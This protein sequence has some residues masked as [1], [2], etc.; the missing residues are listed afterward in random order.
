MN[1][2]KQLF[3]IDP[4]ITF[5]NHGSFGA[6]PKS[7]FEIYQNWQRRLEQQPV[8]FLGRSYHELIHAARKELAIFLG[9]GNNNLVFVPNATYAV[10]Q[11]ARS[12]QLQPGDEVLTGNHE[13][14]A[15]N[16]TWEFICNKAGAVY[17]QQPIPFSATDG[18]I[19]ESF[20]EGV[21]PRTKLIFLSHI[22][23][24]TALRFPVEE[25]CARARRAGIL[26]LIDGA[27]APGQIPLNLDT[28]QADFYTGNCHK[29]M[30]S[31]KG[32]GFLFASP[33]TQH[34]VEPLVVS[35]GFQDPPEFTSGSQ[36]VDMLTWSG[37][38]DPAA[39][40]SVPAAIQFLSDHNWEDV[41]ATC[42]QKLQKFLP[43]FSE[44][45]GKDVLYRQDHQFIQMAVIELPMLKDITSLKTT[46]YEN[47]Q[48]EVPLIDWN[49][50]HFARIS[51]Q[52]YNSEEDLI[53]LLN[54]LGTLLP[55]HRLK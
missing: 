12:L 47:Y 15:C 55:T 37:T 28:L 29:W 53:H 35:W 13:Y 14:G 24:P 2:I 22:S 51:M 5:L 3:Q 38:H 40:L 21:T 42:H 49:N 26:T 19:V 11:I 39:F 31:P 8:L 6:T 32:A 34:L 1:S 7:V 18:E 4:A 17:K 43:K 44:V 16:Y 9:T 27:H 20:W 46:L 54:A 30:L 52:A 33:Q 45:T 36:F 25:I 10:N 23:S 48:I 41:R 50:R